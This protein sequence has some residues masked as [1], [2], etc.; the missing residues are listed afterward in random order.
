[1]KKNYRHL[2][3]FLLLIFFGAGSV[4]PAFSHGGDDTKQALLWKISGNGLA[5]PS[6]LFGTIHAI[7]PEHFFLSD[8]VKESLGRADQLA[9]EI[10][11]DDPA[12]MLNIQKGA[13][14]ADGSI[15]SLY[16]AEQY[17]IVQ[18]HFSKTMNIDIRY[19]D[20]VKPLM[21][22][23]MLLLQLTECQPESYE[24]R[25][26]ALAQ[27]QGKEITGVETVED[28]IATFEKIP[29]NV[30]AEMLLES[31]EKLEEGKANYKKMVQLYLAQ[32]LSGLEAL[33]KEDYKDEHKVMEEA[34]FTERNKK[35]L[36][37]MEKAAKAKATFFAVGA[38]HLTGENGVLELLRKKGYTLTPM[39]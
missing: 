9:L 13:L 8:A 36:P 10:D 30:Q 29:Y 38:G 3:H 18:Q 11:M 25:L 21:L 33:L 16:T 14:M 19:L 34:L 4:L 26:L 22:N 6:Y 17:Q 35:W 37:V 15:Q 7:C 20:K 5:K 23:S 24:Q 31:I 28:Q 1:M 2:L 32:D 12:M 39:P 27:A